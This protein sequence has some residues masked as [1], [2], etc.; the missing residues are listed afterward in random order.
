MAT[1]CISFDQ[2]C[3]PDLWYTTDRCRGT[4]APQRAH[5]S[6]STLRKT[7]ILTIKQFLIVLRKSTGTIDRH[8]RRCGA[9]RAFDRWWDTDHLFVVHISKHLPCLNATMGLSF[10]P[11]ISVAKTWS[12]GHYFCLAEFW[13]SSH[14]AALFSQVQPG[15]TDEALYEP[16]QV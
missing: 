13:E 1:F 10:A 15:A 11:W 2:C 5:M 3:V 7:L 4:F 12:G 14:R 6:V 8:V 9:V 16:F